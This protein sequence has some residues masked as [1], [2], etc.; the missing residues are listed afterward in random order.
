M[1][2]QVAQ[3]MLV[4]IPGLGISPGYIFMVIIIIY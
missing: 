1:T 2:S 3:E 4:W